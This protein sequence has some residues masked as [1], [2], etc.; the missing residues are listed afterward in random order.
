MGIPKRTIRLKQ[1]VKIAKLAGWTNLVIE[2]K[3]KRSMVLGNVP[4]DHPNYIYGFL[5][6]YMVPDYFNSWDAILPVLQKLPKETINAMG[7]ILRQK[8]YVILH[9][10]EELSEALCEVLGE[11]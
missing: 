10:P 7:D 3:G 8:P 2:G 1:V 11:L 5:V 4:R 6:K 9:T